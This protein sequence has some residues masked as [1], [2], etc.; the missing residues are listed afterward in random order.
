MLPYLPLSPHTAHLVHQAFETAG[1]L[2]GVQYYRHL[3]ARADGNGLFSAGTFGLVMGCVLGAALGNKLMFWL[4]NPALW[5]R[6]AHQPLAWL[7]GQSMVGGLIGGLLGVEL[8]KKFTGIRHS[9]GDTF[10]G[11]I[12]L[13]LCIGRIGCFLA[14]L[15][16]GTFGIPTT[17]PWGV[18]FGDGVGRHPTQ[19]YEIIFALLLW[20]CLAHLRPR[21]ATTP[22]LLFKL[23]FSSYLGWRY[24]VDFLKPVPFDYLRQGLGLHDTPFALSGIQLAC[25][26]ALSLYLPWVLRDSR[27]HWRALAASQTGA[28]S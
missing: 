24:L 28:K 7:M 12:L 25:V 20:A 3:R 6:Y 4:E 16:D 18:D 26:L 27:R 1:I 21:L 11:P 5:L 8:A 22:G 10:V 23:M 15:H 17:L 19:L 13:G 2:L 9:T 14:G